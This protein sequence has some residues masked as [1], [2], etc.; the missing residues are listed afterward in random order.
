[1]KKEF[2]WI[3]AL[4]IGITILFFYQIVLFSK[5]PFPGDGLVSDFQP[6]RSASYLGYN[7]GSIPNKAQYPDTYRQLYPW[8]T[9][10]VKAL[11]AGKLP[12]W[13]PYNF[14]GTPLLANFQSSSLYP[15]NILYLIF[16][17]ISAWTILIVLQPLLATLFM[18]WYCRKVDMHPYGAI[19]ASVSF[20]FSGFISVWLE[21]NTVGHVV[22]WFPLI[23][24]CIEELR[25]RPTVLW[26]G[27]FTIAHIASLLAGHPQVYAYVCIFSLIYMYI[28]TD[29]KMHPYVIGFWL[30][31]IGV[32]AIQIVPGLELILH[33]ARSSHDFTYL[34]T[35]ILIQPW[36]VLSMPFPNIFGN[37][38]TRTYWPDDTFVGKVTTI[39]L[40]PLLF[41]FSSF[42]NKN[43]LT[44][45]FLC[46]AMTTLLLIT[47]NP[48]TWIIY[49]FPI[50]FVS[51]STPTLQ[52]FLFV[53]A[54]SVLSGLG[55]DFWLANKH[56]IKTYVFQSLRIAFV[57]GI[58]FLFTKI[59]MLSFFSGHAPVAIRA[60]IYGAGIMIIS[61]L[62]C[63]SII[64]L[65]KIRAGA[66]VILLF[67]H[68]LDLFVFFQRFNPFVPKEMIFPDH[69]VL[70]YLKNKSPDRYWGY[71]TAGI[72]PNFGSQYAMFSPEGYDPLYP[73]W[74]GQYLYG[75][76]TGQLFEKFDNATR[77]DA[78]ITSYFGDGGLSDKNKQKILNSLSVRY[79][80]DR[81]ENGSDE[82]IFP[83]NI[84]S[85]DYS[86]EDWR[87][88][89]NLNAI[90]RVYLVQDIQRYS[91]ALSFGD[92]FFSTHFDIRMSVLLEN[93][94]QGIQ[95]VNSGGT[96]E[97]KK[98]E[99]EYI[100]IHTETESPAVLVLMDTY[101]PGWY[102]Y[103]DGVSADI[104]RANW[105]FRAVVVPSGSHTVIM[106]YKPWSVKIGKAISILSLLIAIVALYN[107]QKKHV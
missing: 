103:I 58:L 55:F 32:T 27:L 49:R 16:S 84:F 107:I 28:R 31:S 69:A 19:L 99:P 14:S 45:L 80:L 34:Y 102:A 66:V 54:L 50:P 20:G 73:K 41:I 24:L 6:W 48:I 75:Y 38:A 74:Y 39:G 44:K 3:G 70:S 59:P 60:L 79:I 96:A 72:S 104:L 5:V 8:K 83:P 21:Y 92:I 98:Y 7:P 93:L 89:K 9:L 85:L 36:Q 42:K 29:K 53:F 67:I 46:T 61:I 95:N 97:I 51:S 57:F 43:S 33:S 11:R 77:S 82:R 87:I 23:L 100:S 37:P 106:I 76:R 52:S 86:F 15:L 40:I 65:P 63:Y 78:T 81:V 12:L 30:I 64:R 26:L 1:M 25:K 101:Y 17:Q 10:V 18:Y 91:D 88:Y 4:F 13:N 68:V 47:A 2:L 56:D 22:L 35:K 94:P 71:G 62:L 105:S 90:P